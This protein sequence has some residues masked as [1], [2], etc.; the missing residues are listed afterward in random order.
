MTVSSDHSV[1]RSR[2][3]LILSYFP[4]E[5]K[6]TGFKFSYS[7][8]ALI[9][10]IYSYHC[11]NHE[12]WNTRAKVHTS[13]Y[14]TF[15][16]MHSNHHIFLEPI[17]IAHFNQIHIEHGQ[18]AQ[19]GSSDLTTLHNKTKLKIIQRLFNFLGMKVS[20]KLSIPL[21]MKWDLS[22]GLTDLFY[23]INFN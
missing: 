7:L 8:H 9:E 23:S 10:S 15:K 16:Y 21:W 2:I 14:Y 5:F 11:G 19:L 17:M 20:Q 13:W 22:V 3:T 12:V 18:A 1:K 4:T 6:K